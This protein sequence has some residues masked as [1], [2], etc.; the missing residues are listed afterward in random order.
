[1]PKVSGADLISDTTEKA[2]RRAVAF[3]YGLVLDV[4]KR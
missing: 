1:M 3:S 2:V 4:A